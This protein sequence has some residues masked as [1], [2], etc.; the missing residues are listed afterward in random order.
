MEF[1]DEEFSKL[2][3][4]LEQYASMVSK[5]QARLEMKEKENA[6][7]EEM[8][9]V[10]QQ[11]KE[12]QHQL[13]VT[14]QKLAEAEARCRDVEQER[15]GWKE[16]CNRMEKV[17]NTAAVENAFLKNCILISLSSIKQFSHLIKR[18][19]LRAL[20]HTFL[21][22]TLSPLMG[23]RGIEAVNEAVEMGDAYDFDKLADQ[24]IIGNEGNVTN[25]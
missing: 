20:I 2:T 22:K 4:K 7:Q 17:V 24:L 21:M 12:V 6:M 13:E 3:G 25:E 9:A 1:N 10:R 8:R 14:N 5:L 15:D 16:Q 19:E 18:V 11:L 23:A